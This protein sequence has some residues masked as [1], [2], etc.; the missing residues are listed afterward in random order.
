LSGPLLDRID[1]HVA[2]PPVEVSALQERIRGEASNVVRKR[3]EAAREIQRERTRREGIH[4]GT[5]AALAQRDLERI[6]SPC[7]AGQRILRAAVDRLALSARGYGKVLRVG[8]TIA[9][10]E[11]STAVAPPHLAEAV[12][13]RVLDR[14]AWAATRPTTEA[15]SASR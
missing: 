7:P 6:A 13:L 12:G 4:A 8:R 14:N 15:V 2:L 3:V 1:V 5:N 10:L 11:G 9:D